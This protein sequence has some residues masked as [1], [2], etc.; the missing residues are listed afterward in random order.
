MELEERVNLFQVRHDLGRLL[1]LGTV[2]RPA[3]GRRRVPEAFFEFILF[4]ATRAFAL[5]AEG[6]WRRKAEF[7]GS[8]RRISYAEISKG[9]RI[10]HLSAD[11]IGDFF[12][13]IDVQKNTEFG[14]V[15]RTRVRDSRTGHD[16]L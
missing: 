14:F 13:R 15:R 5:D 11:Q 16:E 10:F 12:N 9:C 1:W 8:E 6:E 2:A 4:I 3:D 7:E